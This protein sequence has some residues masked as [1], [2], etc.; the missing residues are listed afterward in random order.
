MQARPLS[1]EDT[2]G[3]RPIFSN[4]L[5]GEL[6]PQFLPITER[7]GVKL[8]NWVEIIQDFDDDFPKD[9]VEEKLRTN[10][11]STLPGKLA[12]NG[13]LLAPHTI[14]FF[15]IHTDKEKM[16]TED[17]RKVLMKV[18]GLDGDTKHAVPNRPDVHK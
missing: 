12:L 16:A 18:V 15:C 8:H 10:Q 2:P 14:Q 11:Y 7:L 1:F 9:E 4:R 3:Q 17:G 6:E 5:P 13:P